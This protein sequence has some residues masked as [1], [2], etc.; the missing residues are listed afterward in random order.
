MRLSNV[1]LILQPYTFSESFIPEDIF[2]VKEILDIWIG[3]PF[4]AI[5]NRS[6]ILNVDADAFRWT[7]VY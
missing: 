7:K 3:Y 1:K 5:V 2:G 6:L 4:E